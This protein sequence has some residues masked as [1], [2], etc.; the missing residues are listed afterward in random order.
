MHWPALAS[1]ECG[2]GTAKLEEILPLTSYA[3]R[4]CEHRVLEKTAFFFKKG[5]EE[6]MEAREKGVVILLNEVPLLVY[7]DCSVSVL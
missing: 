4:L 1:K 3:H 6:S 2:K 7:S 5:E